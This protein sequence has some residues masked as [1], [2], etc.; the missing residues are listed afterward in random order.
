LNSAAGKYDVRNFFFSDIDIYDSKA[1][2][3]MIQGN[4]IGNIYMK[5]VVVD[6]AAISDS[7]NSW[8]YYG[9]FFQAS[10]YSNVFCIDFVNMGDVPEN[11][12]VPARG[13]I[14]NSNCEEDVISL[15]VNQTI[16]LNYFIPQN[17][18][19]NMNFTVTSGETNLSVDNQGFV[20]GLNEGTAHVKVTDVDNELNNIIYTL[21]VKDVAVVGFSISETTLTLPVGN[22]HTFITTIE[23]EDATN[24]NIIWS[25]SN[26]NVVK[27]TSGRVVARA[28]GSATITATT[29]DGRYT[30][31]CVITVT[32]ASEVVNTN[33]DKPSIT[34]YNNKIEISGCEDGEIISIYNLLGIKIYSQKLKGKDVEIINNLDKGI[35]VVVAE[36][37]Q[38]KQKVIIK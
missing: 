25:N 6:R 12:T 24:K 21:I 20:L 31:I 22:T 9:L 26:S 33:I 37:A 14:L 30:D 19:E 16:D 29:T 3:I 28:V 2:A 1:N 13:F 5:N 32:P 35:Y 7:G 36:K 11:N 38:I 23:P 4:A 17:F 27:L 10:G 15:R 34:S 18:A 8:E